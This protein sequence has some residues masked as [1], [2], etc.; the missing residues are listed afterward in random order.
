MKKNSLTGSFYFEDYSATT[1]TTR[2]HATQTEFMGEYR[3]TNPPKILWT[4]STDTYFSQLPQN[5]QPISATKNEAIHVEGTDDSAFESA[6]GSTVL[7][8]GCKKRIKFYDNLDVL[9]LRSAMYPEAHL[10]SRGEM[11]IKI[12]ESFNR[13]KELVA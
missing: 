9:L 10:F 13:F 1:D 5:M 11:A 7:A 4:P 6:A 2:E 8:T 3:P 12:T